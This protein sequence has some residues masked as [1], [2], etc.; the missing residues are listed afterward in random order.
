[1]ALFSL[2]VV[3]LAER[4]RLVAD[5]FQFE[6]WFGRYR[7]L[8]FDD[9][10]LRSPLR[11]AVALVLPA[12]VVWLA[13]RLLTGV[14]FGV[15]HLALWIGV[16]LLLFAHGPLR[17]RFRQYLEAARRGDTQSCFNYADSLDESTAMQAAS[18]EELGQRMGQLSAWLNYRYY[19]AVAL[20]F[21]LLGPAMATFYCTV[22]A[23]CDHFAAQDCRR[24]L[25]GPLM[26]LLDWVPVRI[27]S[28]GFAL[29]GH[30]SKAAPVLVPKVLDPFSDPRRMIT[31]VALAAEEVP[32][33]AGEPLCVQ[34]TLA[35]LKLA[36]RNFILLLVVVS[37]L[38]I[39]GVI[40]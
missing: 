2:I 19:A 34:P 38:T 35:L 36:K 5:A 15:L 39:F 6:A 27:V 30:F 4:L 18:V 12:L 31:E 24:P 13:Q 26:K 1:M 21:V 8:M 22:R 37:L 28:L 32:E 11:M 17:Q 10:A 7:R 9:Q 40:H 14:W 3:L 20:Y 33:T 29:S 23:Y 25:L 16:G